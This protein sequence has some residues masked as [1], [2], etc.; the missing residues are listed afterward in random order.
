MQPYQLPWALTLAFFAASVWAQLP[1]G[2]GKAE[3]EKLCKQCH[4]LERAVSLHQD[5]EGWRITM[6]KM[7]TLGTKGKDKELRLV[8]EYLVANFPAEE[9]QKI[10]VNKAGPSNSKAA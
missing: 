8:F 7:V 5:R 1:E 9:I 10:N 4:E 3:T 2:P 6:D